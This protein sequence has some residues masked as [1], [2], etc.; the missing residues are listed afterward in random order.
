MTI[1]SPKCRPTRAETLRGIECV[2]THIRSHLLLVST[3]SLSIIPKERPSHH[4]N[5]E[6]GSKLKHFSYRDPILLPRCGIVTEPMTDL[7]SSTSESTSCD[8]QGP[9]V[10]PST[11]QCLPAGSAHHLLPHSVSRGCLAQIG[12]DWATGGDLLVP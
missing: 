4:R 2:P 6:D 11:Q 9:L 12:G 1:P 10:G 8:Y 3:R 7:R 5:L